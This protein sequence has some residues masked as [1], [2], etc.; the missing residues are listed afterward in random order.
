[1]R[2]SGRAR[3][4]GKKEGVV[5]GRGGG[6]VFLNGQSP[7]SALSKLGQG[8]SSMSPQMGI[9]TKYTALL[10]APSSKISNAHA[11]TWDTGRPR[12]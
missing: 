8:L 7:I 6:A 10:S 1:M 5:G 12:T 4:K 3:G 2:E 9:C 11:E